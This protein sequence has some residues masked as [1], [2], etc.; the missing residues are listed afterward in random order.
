M[1]FTINSL[2]QLFPDNIIS[3]TFPRFSVKSLTFPWQL[4]NSLTFPGFPDKWSP[5]AYSEQVPTPRN[6]DGYGSNGIWHKNN[7]GCMA[8]LTLVLLC[9]AAARLLVVVHW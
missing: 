3:P 4:S 8:G 6:S 2:R 9:V 5:W 7:M 1:Q